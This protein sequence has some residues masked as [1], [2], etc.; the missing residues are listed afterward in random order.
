MP[1]QALYVVPPSKPYTFLRKSTGESP[2]LKTTRAFVPVEVRTS[3]STNSLGL[4]NDE[5][6]LPDEHSREFVNH[7]E[8]EDDIIDDD[9]S[10]EEKA[11]ADLRASKRRRYD[12]NSSIDE[13]NSSFLLGAGS[14]VTS[15]SSL[16][17]SFK[18]KKVQSDSPDSR[19]SDNQHV[20]VSSTQQV[21]YP[22]GQPTATPILIY[23]DIRKKVVQQCI[24]N[25]MSTFHAYSHGEIIASSFTDRFEDLLS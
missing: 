2:F 11:A 22:K 19:D 9:K 13:S 15:T 21:V 7:P 14:S 23:E 1:S 16:E 10:P 24:A 5:S 4:Q 25:S 8:D 20:T 18:K 17:R 12:P 6:D 3:Q